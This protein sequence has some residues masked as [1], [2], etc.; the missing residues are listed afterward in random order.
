[1]QQVAPRLFR[2]GV[3]DQTALLDGQRRVLEEALLQTIHVV[4]CHQFAALVGDQPD[5]QLFQQGNGGGQDDDGSQTEQGI[6]QRYGDGG[7][8]DGHKGKVEDSVG[9]IEHKRPDGRAQHVDQ[10]VH[11]GGALAADIGAQRRQ[12]HGHSS[13]DGDT[14]GD[15]QSDLEGDGAGAGQHLQNTHG[16]AGA[17]QYASEHQ[18]HQN[19]QQGV[20]ELGEDIDEGLT[21]L[22]GSHRAGH[23]SHAVHQHR[24]AQQDI[25]QMLAGGLALYHSQQDTHNGEQS[26][27]RGGG[28]QI[29]PAAAAG[30]AVQAQDPAGDAGAQNGAHDDA[31]GLP[32]LHH[33]RVDEAHHHHG[34]GGGGLNDGGNGGAQQHALQRRA[35]QLIEHQLQLA[36]GHLFQ[37]VAH[38]G[39]AV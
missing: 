15:G 14:H 33:A 20:G 35:R 17:L 31:D 9:G 24:E 5:H 8:G 19:T 11:K 2:H 21:L 22:Q 38:D 28:Q 39:H 12:Q 16:G 13:A 10:Q 37:I 36:A 6:H 34:G 32:H 25:A 4:L 18:T 27:Q 23:G 3:C 29:H 26:R 30:Q 1:M 7:H